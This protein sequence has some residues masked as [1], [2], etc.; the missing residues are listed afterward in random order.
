MFGF[1]LAGLR[2]NTLFDYHDKMA[3]DKAR[4][5]VKKTY[6]KFMS[7]VQ[8][9]LEGRN[10]KRFRDGNLTFQYFEP[11]WLTSSIHI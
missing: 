4:S 7:E 8:R 6:V 10:Q 9:K 2:M 11:K 3:D 1:L 5:L